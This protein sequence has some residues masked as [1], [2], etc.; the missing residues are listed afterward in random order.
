L[1]R[2]PPKALYNRNRVKPPFDIIVGQHIPSIE[3]LFGKDDAVKLGKLFGSYPATA[4]YFNH[5]IANS[6]STYLFPYATGVIPNRILFEEEE[7]IFPK[8]TNV[9]IP[10]ELIV[11]PEGNSD[12]VEF[13]PFLRFCGKTERRMPS[14]RLNLLNYVTPGANRE[15]YRASKEELPQE[16]RCPYAWYKNIDY[17]TGVHKGG[18]RATRKQKNARKLRKSRR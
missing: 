3:T 12:Q 7:D 14:N 5:K 13:L 11:N 8:G 10:K 17:D 6:P 2:M 15:K 1:T 18:N 4:A 9:S 16:F